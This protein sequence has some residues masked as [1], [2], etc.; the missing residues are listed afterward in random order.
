MKR[1]LITGASGFIGACLARELAE[2]GDEVH[3]FLRN[4]SNL[5]RLNGLQDR[6][7]IHRVD[8]TDAENVKAAV[9]EIRPD[10]IYH[11]ATYGA[12]AR[13][14]D[15]KSAMETNV[16]GTVNLLNACASVGFERFVNVSSSSEYGIK[17]KPMREDDV[18]EPNGIYGV[19]KATA[20]LYCQYMA[21]NKGL[22]ITMFRVFAAY[23]YY[24][25][26][27][28]LIPSLIVPCLKNESPKLSSPDSVRDFI[29]VEDVI[30]AL[31]RSTEVPGACGEIMNLGT[32]KQH[33]VKE[34][35]EIVR[36]LT[37]CKK[38]PHWNA[39]EKTGEEPKKWVADMTK[40][41]RILKWKPKHSLESGLKKTA[42]WFSSNMGHYE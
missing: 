25:E 15:E 21:H 14:K 4:T 42:Q 19:T 12:Y 41:E 11:L 7:E 26:P 22:P 5:W 23:G 18:L 28:R 34:A 10:I 24:E 17:D 37:G 40:T 39:V 8:I 9:R 33:T 35:A 27:S 36:E 29:F 13:Q 3:L 31:K 38:E 2:H 6:F 20:T 30:E 1:I 32:G 16:W